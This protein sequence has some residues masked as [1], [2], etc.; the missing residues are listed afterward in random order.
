LLVVAA[1]VA[2]PTGTASSTAKAMEQ[3][4]KACELVWTNAAAYQ[5]QR[6][7]ERAMAALGEDER[8]RDNE[9][10][11]MLIESE[12]E[13][14]ACRAELADLRDDVA[15]TETTAAKRN[16]RFPSRR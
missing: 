14:E 13:L 7:T 5:I 6:C 9:L 8:L 1:A 11:R 15:A 4:R 10:K 12:K 16:P 2:E 3:V